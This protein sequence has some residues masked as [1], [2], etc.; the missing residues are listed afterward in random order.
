MSGLEEM[1][2][3]GDW[4]FFQEAYEH[5]YRR[6]SIYNRGLVFKMKN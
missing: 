5:C 6:E 3:N 4:P 1:V 2:A